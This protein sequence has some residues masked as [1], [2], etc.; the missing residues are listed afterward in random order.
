MV[1][2][3]L[4]VH[5]FTA[6]RP[7]MPA[8][9]SAPVAMPSAHAA[10]TDARNAP[11]AR[12]PPACCVWR[13]AHAQRAPAART[14]SACCRRAG[15]ATPSAWL[16]APCAASWRA[17][18]QR[19]GCGATWAREGGAA[20]YTGRLLPAPCTAPCRFGSCPT[21]TPSSAT[22]S[23]TANRRAKPID[24][25]LPPRRRAGHGLRSHRRRREPGG[26]EQALHALLATVGAA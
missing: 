11:C 26:L 15:C 4:P 23:P 3:N 21:A 1:S 16:S 12:W 13:P 2:L 5:P 14:A 22:P 25:A 19:L 20:I 8:S 17:P 7:A 9:W 18:S 6:K 10:P 24:R